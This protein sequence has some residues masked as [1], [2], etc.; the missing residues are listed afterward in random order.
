MPQG[1]SYVLYTGSGLGAGLLRSNEDVFADFVLCRFNDIVWIDVSRV[2]A[3][4]AVNSIH[5]TVRSDDPV[6]AGAAEQLVY[7]ETAIYAVVTGSA[8]YHIETTAPVAIV[9]ASQ[10][11]ERVCGTQPVDAVQLIG[12]F[13]VVLPKGAP[14]IFGQR[15]PAEQNHTYQQCP[16]K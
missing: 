1:L 4:A 11:P 2:V 12:A 14:Y 13:E 10:T 5:S 6:I 16:T 15:H 8:T 3:R 9:V 7:T